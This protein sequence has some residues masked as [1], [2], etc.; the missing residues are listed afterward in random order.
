M[1]EDEPEEFAGCF[2]KDSEYVEEFNK[3]LKKLEES[4]KLKEILNTYL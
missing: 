2:P 1:Q 4:G 3:A